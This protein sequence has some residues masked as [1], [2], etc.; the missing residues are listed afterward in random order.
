[1]DADVRRAWERAAGDTITEVGRDGAD[2]LY[3]LAHP[4]AADLQAALIA[5]DAAAATTLTGTPLVP[6]PPDGRVARV[7]ATGLPI[8]AAPRRL[9][10]AL[11]LEI[12][13]VSAR[14]WPTLA[15]AA[16]HQVTVGARWER[17]G[18]AAA[19]TDDRAGRLPY[20]L[21]PGASAPV[22]VGV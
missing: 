10:F 17:P 7:R 12:A 14:T 3:A 4:P 22:E 19:R 9:R 15:V 21:V 16:D 18:A 8:D 6:L 5:A 11:A 1:L 13:N 20:D 2:V